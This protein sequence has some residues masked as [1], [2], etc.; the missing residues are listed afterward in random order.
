MLIKSLNAPVSVI[1]PCYRCSSTIH[2]AVQ[3]VVDQT[4][5]PAE[6]ILVD[7][8]SGD[9][10]LG[11]LREI[12]QQYP[13]LIKVISLTENKGAGSA[14]NAGWE[15]ANQPYIALL[16]SDDAWHPQ[17]IAIQYEYMSQHPDV[18]ICAHNY[19]LFE[20]DNNLPAWDLFQTT[21]QVISKSLLLL[22]NRFITPSV[23]MRADISSRFV[24]KQRHMEDHMLWLLVA[25]EGGSIVKLS[26]ELAVIYKRPF[27]IAGLSSNL[28]AME[29]GDLS[30]Y[31]RLFLANYINTYQ[32][33][34][35]TFFSILKYIRRLIIFWGYL[36]WKK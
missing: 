15:I 26:T 6:V 10:T 1:I 33:S 30:N 5:K 2:R 8:A 12:E 11:V 29:K 16:D 13:D 21:A 31:R 36:R 4:Q 20:Q 32:F 3:S 7:D 22:S 34:F 14:R 17:K 27:G 28:W 25:C 23:M 19:R 18:I 9:D 24:E 35:F